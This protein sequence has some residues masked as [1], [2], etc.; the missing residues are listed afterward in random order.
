MKLVMS[1]LF[2][3]VSVVS[4]YLVGELFVVAVVQ[5]EKRVRVYCYKNVEYIAAPSSNAALTLSV[6]NHGVPTKCE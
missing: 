2:V 6:D 5:N 4:L 1:G 3:V